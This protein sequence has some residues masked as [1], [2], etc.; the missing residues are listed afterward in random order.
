MENQ[1]LFNAIIDVTGFTPLES[2]MRE[3]L[4]AIEKDKKP[5]PTPRQTVKPENFWKEAIHHVDFNEYNVDED[6][7]NE[8]FELYAQLRVDEAVR[9]EREKAKVWESRFNELQIELRK[10]RI[11]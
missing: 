1:N 2:D 3:I 9:G 6:L 5:D 4:I 10:Y 11:K 8:S 7:L